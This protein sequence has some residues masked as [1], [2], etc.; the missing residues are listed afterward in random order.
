MLFLGGHLAGCFSA[1]L[2]TDRA[3]LISL[4]TWKRAP[5]GR[6]GPARLGP[7]V[8]VPASGALA[9]L[10][11][12]LI[13][14]QEVRSSILLGSTR[15]GPGNSNLG[16]NRTLVGRRMTGRSRDF[17]LERHRRD[18]VVLLRKTRWVGSSGG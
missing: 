10:G 15:Y 18:N 11:E 14:I 17:P 6:V 13:C 7:A 16:L 12:R 3:V 2:S 1:A 9:Q 5:R 4:R 8:W